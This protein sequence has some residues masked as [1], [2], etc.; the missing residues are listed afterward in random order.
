VYLV[1]RVKSSKRS[2]FQFFQMNP[3]RIHFC[4]F[5]V[6][7]NSEGWKCS[8]RRMK[9]ENKINGFSKNFQ[10]YEEIKHF[11]SVK[12]NNINQ[13]F[14]E[15]K[16]WNSPWGK[17]L[18]DPNAAFML[19]YPAVLTAVAPGG[20]RGFALGLEDPEDELYEEVSYEV[21][22]Y[23]KRCGDFDDVVQLNIAMADLSA[24]NIEKALSIIR[25]F[26]LEEYS[27]EE[28]EEYI[29]RNGYEPI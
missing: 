6:E 2:V 17:G 23:I 29:C 27:S 13:F 7:N 26:V 4:G 25:L 16:R 21:V 22:A 20:E 24:G 11:W 18:N 5:Y 14:P 15:Q 10:L 9:L 8:Y 19:D 28:M 1:H 3:M 12:F